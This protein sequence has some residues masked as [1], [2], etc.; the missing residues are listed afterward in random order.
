MHID[1]ATYKLNKGLVFLLASDVS[2][3]DCH[4][5]V[6]LFDLFCCYF[7]MMIGFDELEQFT[8]SSTEALEIKFGTFNVQQC[9]QWLVIQLLR[10]H[11]CLL[12]AKRD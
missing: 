7:R 9:R 8:C 12:N 2:E 1:T 11:G 3:P 10:F 6:I 4:G 5:Y